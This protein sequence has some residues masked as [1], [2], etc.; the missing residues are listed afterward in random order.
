LNVRQRKKQEDG[1]NYVINNTW[2]H[3]LYSSPYAVKVLKA[4]RM[5]L[6]NQAMRMEKMINSHHIV[7]GKP[8]SMC[9]S[10]KPESVQ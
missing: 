1:E 4:L 3:K 7:V 5:R 2:L 10:S 6:G 8:Q 9:P